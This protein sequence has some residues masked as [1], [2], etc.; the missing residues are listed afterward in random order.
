[1][2]LFL[3]NQCVNSLL[4]CVFTTKPSCPFKY[5]STDNTSGKLIW[6]S[7]RNSRLSNNFFRCWLSFIA[8]MQIFHCK[9]KAQSDWYLLTNKP[10]YGCALSI[11][12]GFE[13]VF[14]FFFFFFPRN[15]HVFYYL[16]LGASVEER[17]EFKLLAPEEY[18][19]L[20]QVQDSTPSSLSFWPEQLSVWVLSS[21]VSFGCCCNSLSSPCIHEGCQAPEYA[22]VFPPSLLHTRCA[23]C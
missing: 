17:K 13:N 2:S 11:R 7:S 18:S 10:N 21:C 4:P 8:L 23:A 5:L 19:Y 16:L 9:H 3:S 12:A 1:M 20:K 15:Y 22:A 14:W 6:T